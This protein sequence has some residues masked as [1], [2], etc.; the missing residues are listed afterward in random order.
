MLYKSKVGCDPASLRKAV[1]IVTFLGTDCIYQG[2]QYTTINNTVH[3]CNQYG[4]SFRGI[5]YIYVRLREMAGLHN[6][7]HVQSLF[8]KMTVRVHQ[9]C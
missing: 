6:K 4:W 7:A 3:V 9:T 1:L 2:A 8:F 5:G